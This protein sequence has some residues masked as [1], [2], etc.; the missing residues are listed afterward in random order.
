[1]GK[2]VLGN[3]TFT[4]LKAKQSYILKMATED[5][6]YLGKESKLSEGEKEIRDSIIKDLKKI[7]KSINK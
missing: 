4:T 3:I 6:K 7:I 1:M 2:F 5:L